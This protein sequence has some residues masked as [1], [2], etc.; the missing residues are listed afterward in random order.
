MG[1][2][3]RKRTIRWPFFPQQ[4]L[5]CIYK[6]GEQPF[7]RDYITQH[8]SATFDNVSER[9]LA[10]PSCTRLLAGEIYTRMD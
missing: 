6:D 4:V 9:A 3:V 1:P 5:Q 8:H 10:R 2:L 7:A